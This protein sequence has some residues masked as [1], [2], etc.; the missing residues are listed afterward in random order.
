[1]YDEK[2]EN[3]VLRSDHHVNEIKWV[4]RMCENEVSGE[5]VRN[6]WDAHSYVNHRENEKIRKVS[7]YWHDRQMVMIGHVQ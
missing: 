3:E 6:E 7:E 1:M 4:E 2:R 5:N